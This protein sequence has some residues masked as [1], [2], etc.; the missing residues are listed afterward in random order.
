M[1]GPIIFGQMYS[2]KKNLEVDV[3]TSI[4]KICRILLAILA[5]ILM[6]NVQAKDASA[7]GEPHFAL[8]I[9]PQEF[10][11]EVRLYEYYYGLW[12]RQ[13]DYLEQAVKSVLDEAHASYAFCESS[14]KH[15]QVLIW[16]SPRIFYNPQFKRYFVSI[17]ARLYG[18][19]NQPIGRVI[20]ESTQDGFLD[21]K[22]ELALEKIY[23]QTMVQLWD[24]LKADQ[25]L[26]SRIQQAGFDMPCAL[27]GALNEP[28][29]REM[30]F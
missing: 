18:Q 6:T 11:H 8:Y 4:L 16:L 5:F 13:G 28:K 24:K 22:P 1:L 25:D 21:V 10:N 9:S 30:A 15:A 7:E 2:L 29:I 19:G 23:H 3:R 27:T 26:D 12:I 20:A 14:P 17:E